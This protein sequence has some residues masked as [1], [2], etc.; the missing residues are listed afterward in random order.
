MHLDTTVL[1]LEDLE[2]LS[3]HIPTGDEIQLLKAYEVVDSCM[4]VCIYV[5]MYV[6]YVCMYVCIHVC[7]YVCMPLT[8][9]T[10]RGRD[11]TAQ[12]LQ[13]GVLMYVCMYVYMYVCM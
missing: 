6:I 11:T 13:G 10:H 7:M 8:A 1:S 9:Y 5:C 4:Y 12:G 3:Q 2:C